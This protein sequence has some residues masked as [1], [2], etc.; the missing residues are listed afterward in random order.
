MVK[1]STPLHKSPDQGQP[2]RR[3]LRDGGL[4]QIEGDRDRDDFLGGNGL[5]TSGLGLVDPLE[6]DVLRF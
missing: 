3:G 6:L 5:Q 1:T 2:V 4:G